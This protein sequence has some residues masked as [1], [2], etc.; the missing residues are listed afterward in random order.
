VD[1]GGA[2]DEGAGGEEGEGALGEKA[3]TE[4]T[5]GGEFADVLGEDALTGTGYPGDERRG[6]EGGEGGAQG[7]AGAVEESPDGAVGDAKGGGDLLV[8]VSG[9]GG[10]EDDLALHVGE[11][12]H[13]GEG[14]AQ[15]QAAGEIGLDDDGG[16]GAGDAVEVQREAAA[17]AGGVT[18]EVD[19]GVVGDAVEPGTELAHGGAAAQGGPGLQE[20]LLDDV[21]GAAVGDGD[22]PAVAQK[23]PAIAVDEGLEGAVVPS[24]SHGEESL[25]GLRGQQAGGCLGTHGWVSSPCSSAEPG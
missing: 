12:G 6:G 22:A 11:G 25:V 4:A 9:E 14:V 18:G 5:A 3:H 13:V 17:G 7:G 10:A 8:A 15:V 23:G 19:G 2:G 21:F 16:L 1:E 24:A 20:G